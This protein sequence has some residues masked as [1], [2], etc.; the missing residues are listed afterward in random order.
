MA[1]RVI[2]IGADNCHRLP[3]LEQAGYT[4]DV[5]T[6]IGE[7]AEALESEDGSGESI[8]ALLLAESETPEE[9][10]SLARAKS[11]APLV[12]FRET[13]RNLGESAFDLVVPILDSPDDWLSSLADLIARS[14]AIRARSIELTCES[15]ALRKETAALR[16]QSRRERARSRRE[17]SRN[18]QL[19]QDFLSEDI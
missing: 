1:A 6:S 5:C 16:D 9:V 14:R 10:I 7:L 17:C 13:Q 12:L 19:V 3:V 8:E 18:S 4:V 15:I 2:H 11:N